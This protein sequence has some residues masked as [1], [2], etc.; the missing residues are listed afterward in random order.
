[1]NVE[2]LPPLKRRWILNNSNIP[3][4]FLDFS[5]DKIVEERGTIPQEIPELVQDCLDGKVIKRI[6]GL[7][8]SGVGLLLAGDPGRGKTTHAVVT[9]LE[10]VAGLPNDEKLAQDILKQYPEQYTT[11]SRPVYYLTMTDFL[12]RKKGLIDADPESRRDLYL[13]MEGFHGRLSTDMDYL[14]VRLLVLDDV[15]KEYGSKYDDASFH[16]LIRSRYDRALPT[17]VTTNIPIDKWAAQYGSAMGSFAHEAFHYVVILGE[18]L[19]KA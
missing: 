1:M 14:N 3:R 13:E 6:G 4:R 15:G 12:S 5:I 7:G 8:E 17:I 2:T 9:C 19:R 10:F 16:E 18:D 11:E